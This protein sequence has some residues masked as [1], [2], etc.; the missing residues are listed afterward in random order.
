MQKTLAQW[1][2]Y[3]KQVKKH[4]QNNNISFCYGEDGS[5]LTIEICNKNIER[6]KNERSNPATDTI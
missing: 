6:F 5:F 2:Y 1:I 4:L 3:F